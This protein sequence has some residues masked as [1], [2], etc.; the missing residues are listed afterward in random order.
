MV[1]DGT[2]DPTA[3]A[4][5]WPRA[6]FVCVHGGPDSAASA[7]KELRVHGTARDRFGLPGTGMTVVAVD[8]D[9][10]QEEELGRAATDADGRYA[11]GYGPEQF[12]LA[13]KGRADLVVR[14][15]SEVAVMAPSATIFNARDDELVD[16]VLDAAAGG[17]ELERL[18]AD[19]EPVLAGVYSGSLQPDEIA[20]IAGD[21]G[22]DAARV[23]MLA[24]AHRLAMTADHPI[25]HFYALLR[26]GLWPELD[27]LVAAAPALIRAVVLR[28]VADA[29]V[30]RRR[31]R[32]STGSSSGCASSAS[33]RSPAA[34]GQTRRRP[35][36][37]GARRARPCQGCEALGGGRRSG[38]LPCDARRPRRHGKPGAAG[39]RGG[40]GGRR[41]APAPRGR[42]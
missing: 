29:V 21:T 1:R 41:H 35:R 20:F 36:R 8:R 3:S 28:A 33:R 38:H 4:P 10:R 16:L 40:R 32:T 25:E 15:L 11:I 12:A 34:S 22:W 5:A 6:P 18:L 27:D 39:V 14:L 26:G 7:V 37:R 19:C 30:R 23:G 42:L 13:E 17:T 2:G 24:Q 9:L 31:P